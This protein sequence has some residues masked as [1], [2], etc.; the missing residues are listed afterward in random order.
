MPLELTKE[1]MTDFLREIKTGRRIVTLKEK[2]LVLQLPSMQIMNEA[3]VIFSKVLMSLLENGVPS[4]AKSQQM[5][6]DQIK[7]MGTDS[8]IL[9]KRDKVLQ[10]IQEAITESNGEEIIAAAKTA[11]DLSRLVTAATNK[12]LNVESASVLEQAASWEYMEMELISNCAE[13]KA[14]GER[15]LYILHKCTL[16]SEGKQL[17]PDFDAIHD[18]TDIDLIQQVQ[19]ELLRLKQG[20]P[21]A[22]EMVIPQVEE[23]L[24][25]D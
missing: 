14:E 22:F 9:Q 25:N 24:K 7:S 12:V 1:E 6:K 13:A 11:A 18:E 16:T 15:D 8:D 10:Q 19:S 5:L 3:S 4:R 20:M 2:I 21:S 23:K 17:W